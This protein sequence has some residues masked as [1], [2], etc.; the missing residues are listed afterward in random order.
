M[1][2]ISRKICLG[3]SIMLFL[4]LVVI[5]AKNNILVKTNNIANYTE[6]TDEIFKKTIYEQ[7]IIN[8]SKCSDEF[9][10]QYFDELT[11][12]NKNISKE[13]EETQKEIKSN[14]LIV[15][16][17]EENI[18]SYGASQVIK[19][20]NN[21]FILVYNTKDEK[22]KAII[23]LDNDKSILDVDENSEYNLF[24]DNLSEAEITYNSWGV[25]KSGLDVATNVANNKSLEEVTVAII[26]TGCNLD[27]L[28]EKFSGKISGTYDVLANEGDFDDKVGHGTHIAGTIA[29]STPNIV[30]I[31]PVK[32]SNSR[33]MYNTDII[34]AINYVVDNNI[35]DVI[36]MSF[37]GYQ[38]DESIYTAIT[39]ANDNNIICVAAAGNDNTSANSYPASY[40]N[41]LSIAACTENLEKASFSNYNNSVTFTAPGV[42]ILS[43]NGTMS[44]TSMATPH[45]VSE[46]AILKSYNK[47]YTLDNT[48]DALKHYCI[49]LGIEGKDKEFGYGFID[50]KDIVYCTCNCENC[51]EIYCLGCQCDNCSLENSTPKE[52]NV[53]KI[54]VVQKFPIR[55]DYNYGSLINLSQMKLKIYYDDYTKEV[56]LLELEDCE[57]IG[58][59]PYCYENQTITVK[60]KEQT[61]SFDLN[62]GGAYEYGWSYELNGDN[63]IKLTEFKDNIQT[64][65]IKVMYIPETIDG[66]TVTE[67]GEDLFYAKG[68]FY[69]VIIP[70]SVN[71]IGDKCFYNNDELKYVEGLAEEIY[72]G[73]YAFYSCDVLESNFKGIIK[74]GN[75][76]FYEC[77]KIKEVEF[78]NGIESIGNSAFFYCISVEELVLPDTVTTIGSYAFASCLNLT[79]VNIP[80]N[81]K[82]IGESAFSYTAITTATIPEGV[83]TIKE[84]T[85]NECN[86]LEN[87][88]LPASLT[89]IETK[90]FYECSNLSSLQIPKGVT[91]ICEDSFLRCSNLASLRVDNKNKVYD[92]REDCNA[93]IEKE[94]N[95]LIMG[96]NNTL[97]PDTVKIIGKNAFDSKINLYSLDIPEGV[98]TIENKAFN[99]CIYLKEIVLPK[100][101]ASI[102]SDS[103]SNCSNLTMYVYK[104]SYSK[105]YAVENDI[106][107]EYI[108][109]EI[110]GVSVQNLRK[111]TYSAFEKVDTTGLVLMVIYDDRTFIDIT[112][113]YKINYENGNDSFR[114]G[115]TKFTISYDNG[116]VVFT[117]D[118]E[119]TVNKAIPEYTIPIGIKAKT[120]KKL[121]DIFLPEGFEWIDENLII[122]QVG[123]IIYKAKFIPEDIINYEIVNDI[124]I[125]VEVIK[126]IPVEITEVSGIN[127]N[128]YTSFEQVNMED[129]YIKVLY[130]TEIIKDI[131]NNISIEYTTGNDSFRYGDTKYT[132]I[133]VEDDV[134]LTK[135]VSV[136]VVK[137]IPEYTIPIGLE[138]KIGQTL[139]EIDLPN[140]FEW[141]DNTQIIEGIGN[142]TYKAKYIPSDTKN[143]KIIENIAIQV[144]IITED[145]KDETIKKG[146]INKDG[147][148]NVND[149]IYG[150]KGFTK[151]TLTAEEK[152]IGNVNGDS[153]FNINDIIKIMKYIVGK[154]STLN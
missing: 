40:D 153:I 42:N 105:E 121:S 74:L 28:E 107:Y 1:K 4:L 45:V 115:D 136:T 53:N 36:N 151:G 2:K 104:E 33:S 88:T 8:I 152:E 9:M 20:P 39:A 30:K 91:S 46:V 19:A 38:K 41:T 133:Y 70:T 134:K 85:F 27:L 76:A 126:S 43:V 77:K 60:Y 3:I 130:A 81:I 147:M 148:I 63:T 125:T 113:G 23:N 112:D 78:S 55:L 93:I 84:E 64:Q 17:K 6:T 131:T 13:D 101:V 87:L 44:G 141:M 56:Y 31:F 29:E 51:D 16:S 90:A 142:V 68:Y 128:T 62:V 96:T 25:E 144:N 72:I 127:T 143:Y 154:I 12:L 21:Q 65:G 50:L 106:N 49:D 122:E 35:A 100:S 86:N 140:G 54:E 123:N 110:L 116:T 26:D 24:Y 95:K 82:E 135:D 138:T 52:E 132:V 124:E 7:D 75:S 118:I 99:E 98:T 15:T 80:I 10:S 145:E 58:Y 11:T 22:D 48:I 47:N 73:N 120:G 139:A 102:A 57:I 18:N 89:T 111:T 67:L 149:I 114:Y 92:S 150:G 94:T 97:I 137:A 108:D 59:D 37:G 79:K 32:V 14:M 146:D 103:F 83:T 5:V 117:K 71:K 66:Y 34:L 69:K 119:V 109:K 129:M 61:T